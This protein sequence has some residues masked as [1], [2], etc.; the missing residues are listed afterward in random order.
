MEITPVLVPDR[1]GERRVWRDLLGHRSNPDRVKPSV[2]SNC[3]WS[4]WPVGVVPQ[5]ALQSRGAQR[6]AEVPRRAGSEWHHHRV[7]RQRLQVWAAEGAVELGL[8]DLPI[9]HDQLSIE[10]IER[11][12][13]QVAVLQQ[14]VERDVAVKRAAEQRLNRG[15]LKQLVWQ[16][17]DVQPIVTKQVDVQG[18]EEF[19]LAHESRAA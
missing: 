5:P 6:T 8:E 19:K 11:A 17:R 3:G 1:F 9:D 7:R 13:A 10:T 12:Q 16:P 14:L 18:V 15:C 4:T 2:D